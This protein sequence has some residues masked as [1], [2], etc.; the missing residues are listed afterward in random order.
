MRLKLPLSDRVEQG[1]IF[2]CVSLPGYE[3]CHCW[4]IVLTAR[5]DLAHDKFSAI[6]YLPIVRFT[7]CLARHFAMPIAKRTQ[8]ELEKKFAEWFEKK[9]VS[10]QVRATFPFEDII[11]RE[12]NDRER[13]GWLEFNNQLC[14]ARSILKKAGVFDPLAANALLPKR[15]KETKDLVEDLIKQKLGEFYFLESVDCGESPEE[16]FVV[17]LRNMRTLDPAIM[18]G[19]VSG[20][21]AESAR[22]F[23]L[24]EHHLTFE[25]EH[26]CMLTGVLRSPDLEHLTQQFAHLFVHIGLED[27]KASTIA[28]HVKLAKRI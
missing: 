15:G 20:L 10:E 8:K 21:T 7:D 6:N 25:R 16:G 24:C 23:P 28:N 11:L 19:V 1:A 22:Q 9:N 27:Q 18:N 4:G 12:A 17:L 2:N 26:L 13:D 5:C 3:G 14:A